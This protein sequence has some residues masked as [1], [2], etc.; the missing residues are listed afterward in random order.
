[1]VS[2]PVAYTALIALVG[3]ERLA[4][5]RLSRR[6]AAASFARGAVEVGRGHYGVMSV[7]HGAFLAACVAEA[8]W[9]GRPFPGALGWAAL[10]GAALAQALRYWAI[11]TLGDRWNTRVIV[12]P[13]AEPVTGGPYRYL[14]HPNYLAVVL[15]MACLPL[16]HGGWW[17]ALVFSLGNAAILW[18]RVRAEE[19]AL[20]PRYAAAF[21]G[22]GRFVPE[23]SRG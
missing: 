8:W 4:E 16:V 23:V 9:V 7:F 13:D 14:K 18:V 21:A 5:L 3:V 12:L 22:R 19:A 20:G 10:A 6:H 15:E 1:M 17:T 2:G 11:A